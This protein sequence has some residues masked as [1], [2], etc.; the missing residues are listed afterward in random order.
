MHVIWEVS[1]AFLWGSGFKV[2][3]FDKLNTVNLSE[4]TQSS[5]EGSF[6]IVRKLVS[7]IV[8]SSHWE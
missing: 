6:K 3:Y 5:A 2:A 4:A 1:D 8:S 7:E